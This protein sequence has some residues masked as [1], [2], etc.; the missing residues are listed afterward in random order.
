MSSF[1]TG[2]I[3]SF[4]IWRKS[5]WNFSS[6]FANWESFISIPSLKAIFQFSQQ[7]KDHFALSPFS[8][9][10]IE[11]SK[12]SIKGQPW[13]CQRNHD[14]IIYNFGH[15]SCHRE[16]IWPLLKLLQHLKLLL[17]QTW[18]IFVFRKLDPYT[19]VHFLFSTVCFLFFSFL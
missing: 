7:S 17:N 4:K 13:M 9:I 6:Q 12:L 19:N 1:V 14:D 11:S 10:K 3:L 16:F 2:N 5:W 15:C 18:K 8:R